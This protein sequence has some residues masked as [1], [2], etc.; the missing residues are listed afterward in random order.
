MIRFLIHWFTIRVIGYSAYCGG[1]TWKA[2]KGVNKEYEGNESWA[3]G[4]KEAF[5]I[6]HSLYHPHNS[7]IMSDILMFT[8]P[9]LLGWVIL[10]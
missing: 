2:L 8:S 3:N 1:L 10:F 5:R 9:A 4:K 7:N 6:T